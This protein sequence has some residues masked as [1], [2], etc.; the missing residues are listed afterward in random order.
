MA[1]VIEIEEELMEKLGSYGT[2]LDEVILR[3]L[4]VLQEFHGNGSRT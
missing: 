4:C 2:D 1:R 3:S